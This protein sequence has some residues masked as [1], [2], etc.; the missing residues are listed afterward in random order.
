MSTLKQ[1]FYQTFFGFKENVSII[2]GVLLLISMIKYSHFFVYLK[3]LKD[4]FFS[5][6]IADMVWSIS[7]WNPINSYIIASQIWN[8]QDKI[9]IIST[10]LIAWVTVGFVQIP[11]EIYFF[12]K[13]FALTRNLVS[14][15]FAILASVMIY[16]LY[17]IV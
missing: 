13:K 3:N 11:A 8:L 7:A 5:V 15:I 16:F 4:D 10:F 9:I 1:K 14:F 17:K 2:I 12:W 6:I